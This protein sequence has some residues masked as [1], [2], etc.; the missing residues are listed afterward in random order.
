[1]DAR[2]SAC[3][4]RPVL[5]ALRLLALTLLPTI[6]SRV[7]HG[8]RRPSWSFT[9][10]WA[11][12]YLRRDWDE[13]AERPLAEQRAVVAARPA[14]PP[15]QRGLRT[16]DDEIAGVPVRRFVPAAARAGAQLVYFHGG[17]YVYGS[18]EHS[19][20][21]VCARL[22]LAT[23][24][25]VIGVE[26]RLAPEHPWPAQ[27]DDAL[28][29]C[30]ALDAALVLAGDSAGGHLAVETSA[31]LGRKPLALALVSPWCDLAMP[32]A[33]FVANDAFEIGTRAVLVRHAAAVG[34]DGRLEASAG[35]PPTFVT[36]GEV[37]ACRDDIEAFVA[38]LRGAGVAVTVH[39]ARDLPHDPVLFASL[40]PEAQAALEALAQFVRAAV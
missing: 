22:A 31:L 28:A 3:D 20:A 14:P 11:V 21:E 33:S 10:E 16:R 27:L 37:E 29:V 9:F 15:P 40:H 12:R 32:G 4:D 23:A 30:R 1:M 8:P 39:V 13:T 5:R 6:V 24:L 2:D 35:M 19:H 7:R 17:S 18:V 25:E 36:Y 34:L 26:Y 38:R